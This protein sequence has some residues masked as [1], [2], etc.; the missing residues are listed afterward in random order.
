MEPELQLQQQWKYQ[1]ELERIHDSYRTQLR[2]EGRRCMEHVHELYQELER[3]GEALQTAEL[4]TAQHVS[5]TEAALLHLRERKAR[6]NA[7]TVETVKRLARI[8]ENVV[9]CLD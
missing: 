2:D 1:Q 5:Q 3:R 7:Q 9:P 8:E 4:Q 6:H